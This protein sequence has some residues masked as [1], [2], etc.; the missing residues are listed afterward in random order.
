MQNQYTKKNCDPCEWSL[1]GSQKYLLQ[2]HFYTNMNLSF[3]YIFHELLEAPSYTE[4][5]K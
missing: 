3:N 5:K 2:K 1:K 4:K